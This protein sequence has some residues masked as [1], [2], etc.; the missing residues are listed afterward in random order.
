[1]AAKESMTTSFTEPYIDHQLG[2]YVISVSTPLLKNGKFIGVLTADLDFE[3]FQKE[4]ATLFPLANGSAFLMV[5]GKNI[6]DQTEQIL[7]L[8]DTQTKEVLQ[9]FQLKNKETSKFLSKTSPIFLY[10]IR[11]QIANGC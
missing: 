2:I 7:D 1:M 10:M 8:S 6:L 5:D 3:I 4:L 11:L 9:K